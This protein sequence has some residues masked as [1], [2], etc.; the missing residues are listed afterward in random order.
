MIWMQ[1]YSASPSTERGVTPLSRG[2][3]SCTFRCWRISNPREKSLGVTEFTAT[4]ME[5][6]N[7]LSLSSTRRGKSTGA[8][9]R[10]SESIQERMEFFRRWKICKANTQPQPPRRRDDQLNTVEVA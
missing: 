6:P 4:R 1:H 10:Q 9:F 8:M 7:E 3:A 2:T 5:Y